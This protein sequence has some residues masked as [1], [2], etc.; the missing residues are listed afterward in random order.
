MEAYGYADAG[1]RRAATNATVFEAA[2]LGKPVFAYAVLKLADAGR[3]DIDAPLIGL[4][5]ALAE[6]GEFGGTITARHVLSHTTG[7]PNWRSEARPFQCHFPPGKRFSYS[8]EGYVCL[9]SAIE[10]L[11]SEPLDAVARRL[12]FEP[13]GMSRSSYDA[14][15][16]GAAIAIPHDRDGPLQKIARKPNAAS[17]LHTTAEDYARFLQAVLEGEGLSSA[18]A[19]E[20]LRPNR[21]VPA[22]FF[23][24]LD[25]VG[26]PALHPS[27]A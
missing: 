18:M 14:A 8:G 10:R 15:L 25:P 21:R 12:V 17:S 3:L 1:A 9:Q 19:R 20:W 7:L 23:A 24:A 2:S 27:V 4:A 13:L 6:A 11:T 16:S 5:P 26:E 22:S